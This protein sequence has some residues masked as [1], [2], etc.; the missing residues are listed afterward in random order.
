[1]AKAILRADV[2]TTL[3]VT[4]TTK[5]K[6]TPKKIKGIKIPGIQPRN[7]KEQK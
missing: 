6:M 4:K 2:G 1:M 3:G 7:Y 5:G